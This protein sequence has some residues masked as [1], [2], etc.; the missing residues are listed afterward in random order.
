MSGLNQL[1]PVVAQAE[2]Q[3]E[4][5][6]LPP[7]KAV[8]YLLSKGVDPR[9]ASLV[10]KYRM[11]KQSAANAPGKAP[12]PK[13]VSQDVDE[14]I[15][16][17]HA[18]RNQGVA[19]LPVSNDTFGMAG[20]GIIAFDGGGM[21]SATDPSDLAAM[22]QMQFY[23][24]LSDQQ[25]QQQAQQIG[26]G[27]GMACGGTV[28]FDEGGYTYSR[29]PLHRSDTSPAH[30]IAALKD[31]D[32][33]YDDQAN[34]NYT[35]THRGQKA[36]DELRQ[37]IADTDKYG[38]LDHNKRGGT[39][40][41]DEGGETDQDV[42]DQ[43][44]Q[45]YNRMIRDYRLNTTQGYLSGKNKQLGVAPV[46]GQKHGGKIKHFDDGGW[47]GV[48]QQ[49][50]QIPGQFSQLGSQISNALNSPS[51]P[52]IPPDVQHEIDSHIASG[53]PLSPRAAQIYQQITGGKGQGVAPPGA[54]PPAPPA[55]QGQGNPPVGGQPMLGMP[56]QPQ[57]RQFGPGQN[58]QPAQ[59]GAPAG[60]PPPQQPPNT[61]AATSSMARD[62]ATNPKADAMMNQ[63]LAQSRGNVAEAKANVG[64]PE[65]NTEHILDIYAKEG[66]GAA[67]K[68][69][70]AYL[71]QLQSQY[72]T[73]EAKGNKMAIIQL[74]L[75]MAQAATQNPH[76]GFLGA[77][78]VGGQ[79]GAKAYQEN[80]EKYRDLNT[81]VMDQRYQVQEAQENIKANATKEGLQEYNNKLTRLDNLIGREDAATL[82]AVELYAGRENSIRSARAMVQAK[83]QG[84][85]QVAAYD[86]L[87]AKG[88]DPVEALK[89]VYAQTPQVQAAGERGSAGLSETQLKQ[90]YGAIGPETYQSYMRQ[91][92]NPNLDPAKRAS[93]Q[94]WVNQ[95]L[96]DTGGGGGGGQAMDLNDY[97]KAHQ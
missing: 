2:Q 74:G 68:E 91:L 78:A 94:S 38:Q 16:A 39:I 31:K 86:A 69:H 15:N 53:T 33:L 1:D 67:A 7:D 44:N 81:K 37:T 25:S 34:Y 66:I 27:A 4:R 23:Q 49:L 18:Q 24:N 93:I 64:T 80:L 61:S 5:Q 76:G 32:G 77:L 75:S 54:K 55:P 89:K 59:G 92:Q 72:S 56:Q 17:A 8:D 47:A 13:T 79:T 46:Q 43:Q 65:S 88:T 58:V 26:Q 20:G 90:R 71:D 73:L 21:P 3:I 60:A 40:H 95:F 36:A 70:L 52:S 84:N 29:G 12:P 6:K 82:R 63:A 50:G 22:Q 62:S 14:Q 11:L 51:P 83:F 19:G 30:Q 35:R 9:L 85:I 42:E 41:M 28:A 45:V 96:A 57:P 97:L 87:I 10:M 48:G